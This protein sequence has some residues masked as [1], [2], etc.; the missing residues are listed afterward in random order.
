MNYFSYLCIG[1]EYKD[2][3]CSSYMKLIPHKIPPRTKTKVPWFLKSLHHKQRNVELLWPNMHLGTAMVHW[4]TEQIGMLALECS[5]GTTKNLLFTT[6][7]A[8]INILASL[9]SWESRSSWKLTN[10]VVFHWPIA[11]CF[12]LLLWFRFNF[13]QDHHWS[14]EAHRHTFGAGDSLWQ[15]SHS[16]SFPA[17]WF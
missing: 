13:L 1:N 16:T 4:G 14:R 3:N 5:Q 15:Y 7:T 12:W 11:S 6:Q 17:F 9:D 2:G 10:L 8:F